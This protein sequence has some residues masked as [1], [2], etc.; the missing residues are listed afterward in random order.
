MVERKE[1][2]LG[3]FEQ[4]V[5][6]TL[7]RLKDNAYGVS[8]RAELA[9]QTKLPVSFGSVYATLER[10]EQKG[11]VR[12]S[13]GDPTP[14]RGGRPKRYYALEGSGIRALR[15]SRRVQESM[16]AGVRL[17]AATPV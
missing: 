6:L 10:L 4:G 3:W 16:W 13:L 17:P 8:I 2:A 7:W 12:S 9:S 15:K 14:E 1:L 11:F 5:L